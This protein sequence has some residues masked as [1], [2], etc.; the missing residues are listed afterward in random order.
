M[1]GDTLCVLCEGVGEIT[2]EFD[3]RFYSRDTFASVTIPDADLRRR[4]TLHAVARER[5]EEGRH[6]D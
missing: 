3:R 6:G 2:R 1:H 4:G 5:R